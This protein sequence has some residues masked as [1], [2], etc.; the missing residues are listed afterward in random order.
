REYEELKPLFAATSYTPVGFG[1]PLNERLAEHPRGK[2][3]QRRLA[4]SAW[5][6]IS[7]TFEDDHSRAV[8]VWMAYQ[9]VEPPEAAMTGRLAYANCAGRQGRAWTT[10]NGRS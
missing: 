8:M 3:W 1:K 2:L 4:M 7:D 5:E 10:L 6:I 9:T